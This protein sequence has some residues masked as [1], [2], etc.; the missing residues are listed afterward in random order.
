MDTQNKTTTTSTI[1]KTKIKYINY[2]VHG[3][4][5]MFLT[6]FLINEG[7]KIK[8]IV[9]DFKEHFFVVNLA[10]IILFSIIMYFDPYNVIKV[11][12]EDRMAMKTATKHAIIAFIISLFAHLDLI[13]GSFFLVWY[14]VYLTDDEVEM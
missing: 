8:I 9:S 14:F 3:M 4:F 1:K 5:F 6:I 13:F 7:H 12:N 2:I 10:I 11:N